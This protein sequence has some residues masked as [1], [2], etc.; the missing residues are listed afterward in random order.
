MKKIRIGRGNGSKRGNTAG[1]GNKGQKSRS[2][3][4][5]KKFFIGGQ[6]PINILRPKLGFKSKTNNKRPRQLQFY[7]NTKLTIFNIRHTGI[8]KTQIEITGGNVYK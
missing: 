5:K 1:R 2:G 4:N 6:T 7:K 3:Y 8:K